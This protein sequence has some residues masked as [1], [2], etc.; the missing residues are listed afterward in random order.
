[1]TDDSREF[2]DVL[3]KYYDGEPDSLTVEL[4]GSP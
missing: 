2:V 1:V 3:E 4:L